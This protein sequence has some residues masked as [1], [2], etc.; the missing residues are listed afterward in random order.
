MSSTTLNGIV[1]YD[2]ATFLD[3]RLTETGQPAP[4]DGLRDERLQAGLQR[5][6]DARICK[7]A[8][9]SAQAPTV[10]YSLGLVDQQG[11]ARSPRRSGTARR[12]RR[13]ST[14]ARDRGGQ[15]R[16]LFARPA[17]RRRS[18]RR[19]A[20]RRRSGCWSRTT[21]DSATSR[22]TITT[23]CAIRASQKIGYRRRRA[24][25]AADAALTVTDLRGAGRSP[26][27]SAGIVISKGPPC[28]ST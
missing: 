8:E 26:T 4:I 11:A 13:G 19:R 20:R 28:V 14:S 15:R 27:R 6:A 21:T 25:Q 17:A 18:S 9:K 12:S 3:T 5:R 2:W 23:A 7:Q 10:S 24:G 1:P 22:S 16:G